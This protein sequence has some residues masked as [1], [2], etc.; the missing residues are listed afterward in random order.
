MVEIVGATFAGSCSMG[1][2][3][4]CHVRTGLYCAVSYFVNFHGQW[5][6]HDLLEK[7]LSLLA[8]LARC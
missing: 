6:V 8:A 3:A 2:H 5:A 1:L 4:A 7:R